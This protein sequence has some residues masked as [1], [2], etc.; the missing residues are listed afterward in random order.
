[1]KNFL[2]AA[3]LSI[4]GVALGLGVHIIYLAILVSLPA[5]EYSGARLGE[6]FA[7]Q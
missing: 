5:Q 1:M 2:N 3:A 7:G 4:S 6:R